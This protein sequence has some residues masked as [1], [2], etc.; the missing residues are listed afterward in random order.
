MQL[1]Q[2][3]TRRHG[4]FILLHAI[5]IIS[6]HVAE[7]LLNPENDDNQASANIFVVSFL[8]YIFIFLHIFQ[9][10]V[11]VVLFYCLLSATDRTFL[12]STDDSLVVSSKMSIII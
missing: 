4:V 7:F 10:F 11:G 5:S 1:R 2:V 6:P 3:Y 8:F 12:F 9:F